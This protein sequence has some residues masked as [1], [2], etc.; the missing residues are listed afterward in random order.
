MIRHEDPGEDIFGPELKNRVAEYFEQLM[1][2]YDYF[3]RFKA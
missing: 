2:L 3:N 1:P